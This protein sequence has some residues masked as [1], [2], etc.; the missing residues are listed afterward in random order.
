M[1]KKEKL[2][3]TFFHAIGEDDDD[4]ESTTAAKEEPKGE[5]SGETVSEQPEPKKEETKQ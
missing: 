2:Q 3:W 1:A 5:Q 4:D